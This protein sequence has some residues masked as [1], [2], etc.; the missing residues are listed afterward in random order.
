MVVSDVVKSKVKLKFNVHAF[1]V[2]KHWSPVTKLD[3][4]K[5]VENR[6]GIAIRLDYYITGRQQ[7]MQQA[8]LLY[9][10]RP[11]AHQRD[12]STR[13]FY[14]GGGKKSR[15]IGNLGSALSLWLF[16]LISSPPRSKPCPPGFLKW[17]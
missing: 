2:K 4:P 8:R 14:A 13:L 10:R 12:L 15:W 6:Q 5:A 11:A 7:E 1:K 3:A 17:L 9:S 16:A